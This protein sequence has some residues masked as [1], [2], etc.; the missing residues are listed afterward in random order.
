LFGA[1]ADV[2]EPLRLYQHLLAGDA[3]SAD[4]VISDATKEKP[5]AE[6]CDE[7]LVPVLSELKRELGSRA[8][9][10][11]QAERVVETLEMTISSIPPAGANSKNVRVVC[12]PGQNL[13][14]QC[15]ARLLA[16]TLASAG[17]AT[18]ALAVDLLANEAADR[19]QQANATHAVVLQVPPVSY[20]HSRRLIVTLAARLDESTQIYDLSAGAEGPPQIHRSGDPDLPQLHHVNSF[21]KVVAEITEKAS[22]SREQV[23]PA[24]A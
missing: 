6:V 18:Q 23:A 15:A 10:L 22:I 2:P 17:I 16:T 7:L 5:L 14:D 20:V 21:A 8:I 24:R 12:L 19:T 13:V 3:D 9:D 11:E 1:D 4:E